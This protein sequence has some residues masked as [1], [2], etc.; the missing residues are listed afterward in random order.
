[1]HKESAQCDKILIFFNANGAVS[2][3]TRLEIDYYIDAT[4]WFF[5]GKIG[6][7]R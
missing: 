7:N 5:P 4:V 3:K 2:G 6:L 1:M